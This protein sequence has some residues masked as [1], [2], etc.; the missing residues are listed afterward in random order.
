M[1]SDQNIIDAILTKRATQSFRL[2]VE[3]YQSSVFTICYRIIKNREVAEEVAQ[4]VFVKSFRNLNNLKEKGKFRSWLMR[5]AYTMSIDH[6]RLK[7]QPILEDI[8]A[9]QPSMRELMTPFTQLEVSEKRHILTSAVNKL[10]KEQSLVITLFYLEDLP[11][12][13]IVEM[14]GLSKSNVKV[15]LYRGRKNLR[16]IISPPIKNELLND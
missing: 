12:N 9:S 11:I 6:V 7:G 1:E 3:K 4:D 16:E 5:I 13:E 15:L 2:L 10:D 14:T 8:E